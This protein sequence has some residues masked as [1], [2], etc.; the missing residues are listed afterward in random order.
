MSNFTL[1]E[2]ARQIAALEAQRADAALE[3]KAIYD[4]AKHY[5]FSVKALRAA[6]KVHSMTPGKRAE[7]DEVQADI[8]T[9][10]ADLDGRRIE[11]AKTQTEA[12]LAYLEQS[13][14][15]RSAAE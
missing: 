5:N 7:H 4:A 10:L 15:V 2:A 1:K 13:R 11:D 12:N 9:Y 6:I 8:E 3:I 14:K